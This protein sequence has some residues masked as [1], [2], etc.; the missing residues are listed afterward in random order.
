MARDRK[1]ARQAER[2]A[3]AEVQAAAFYKEGRKWWYRA[4]LVIPVIV[5]ASFLSVVLAIVL[6]VGLVALFGQ[7]LR[8]AVQ[9]TK[10][11][12]SVPEPD[13]R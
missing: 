5:A 13:G 10:L 6:G 1:L 4:V 12:E 7:G 2:R 8:I 9:G 3:A 11:L